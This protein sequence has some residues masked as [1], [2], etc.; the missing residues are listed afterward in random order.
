MS[1]NILIFVFACMLLICSLGYNDVFAK[2]VYYDFSTDPNLGDHCFAW[3][4]WPGWATYNDWK[5]NWNN[6]VWKC[7]FINH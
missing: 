1:K 5:K 4:Q 2:G 3:D 7:L 6:G